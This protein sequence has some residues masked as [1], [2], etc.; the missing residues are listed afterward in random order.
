MKNAHRQMSAIKAVPNSDAANLNLKLAKLLIGYMCIKSHTNPQTFSHNWLNFDF[1]H[2]FQKFLYYHVSYSIY[3]LSCK[4]VRLC[5]WLEMHKLILMCIEGHY[6]IYF[7]R[8]VIT[9]KGSSS[10]W[11]LISI[12]CY[13]FTTYIRSMVIHPLW[14][15]MFQVFSILSNT[16]IIW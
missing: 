8:I 11:N 10:N 14:D 12:L 1:W 7:A 16:K 6:N 15:S 2:N 5:G 9:P 3:M 4:C 13:S